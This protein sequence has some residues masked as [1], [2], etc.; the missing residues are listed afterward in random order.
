MAAEV[1]GVGLSGCDILCT[2]CAGG[3][4]FLYQIDFSSKVIGNYYLLQ[5]V[6]TS[7]VPS[8]LG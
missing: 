2:A 3:Y 1:V 7:S 5:A 4:Y 8:S 6:V